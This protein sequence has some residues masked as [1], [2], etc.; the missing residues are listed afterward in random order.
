MLI[1]IFISII[2]PHGFCHQI[3]PLWLEL[4]LAML[5]YFILT[6]HII[7]FWGMAC[8]AKLL[9]TIEPRLVCFGK[10]R[11]ALFMRFLILNYTIFA[12]LLLY[13]YIYYIYIYIYNNINANKIYK[14]SQYKT[15]MI[16]LIFFSFT[17]IIYSIYKL[18]VSSHK[19]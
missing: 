15:I 12:Y 11:K 4:H 2:T 8:H 9:L 10:V 18:S 3:L 1:F 6:T 13:I 17:T 16:L 14:L 5:F 19:C 7:C